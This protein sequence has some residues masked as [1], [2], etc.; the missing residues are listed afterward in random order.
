MLYV[1]AALVTYAPYVEVRT[2]TI[3][4]ALD[5]ANA[6]H[7]SVTIAR[8]R[9]LALKEHHRRSLTV[10]VGRPSLLTATGHKIFHLVSVAILDIVLPT[11]SVPFPLEHIVVEL[12]ALVDLVAV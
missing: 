8:V 2:L 6:W 12:H 11:H 9:V 4:R 1:V 3:V 7:T 5:R 10:D